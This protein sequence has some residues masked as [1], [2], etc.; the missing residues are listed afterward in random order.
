MSCTYTAHALVGVEIDPK[1]LWRTVT[2]RSCAHD[3][4][5]GARY[6][7]TCGK[8]ALTERVDMVEGYDGDDKL[9]VVQLV[10]STDKEQ[11]FAVY[12]QAVTRRDCAAVVSLPDPEV[13][14]TWLR[15]QLLP[16]GLWNVDKFG[17]WSVLHCSY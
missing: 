17:L 6:C 9:G 13:A 4:P 5:D 12:Q 1:S 15:Q 3:L 2:T 7:P 8:P 16:L 14:R 11:C 10:W